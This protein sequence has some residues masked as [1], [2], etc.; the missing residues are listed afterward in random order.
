M[1]MYRGPQ[2]SPSCL[3]ILSHVSLAG[4][5]LSKHPLDNQAVSLSVRRE[6]LG[7]YLISQ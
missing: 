5:Q 1:R 4:Q 6:P 3:K 2:Y 7:D